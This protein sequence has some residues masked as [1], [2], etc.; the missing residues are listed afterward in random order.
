MT[1]MSTLLRTITP[2]WRGVLVALAIVELPR[3][4][5]VWS[6][7]SPRDLG[8]P[9]I[10]SFG[11]TF[12]Y[13]SALV[14]RL[15]PGEGAELPLWISAQ[16]SG[17]QRPYTLRALEDDVREVLATR[18]SGLVQPRPRLGVGAL[19]DAHVRLELTLRG[20]DLMATRV[21][22]VCPPGAPA[23]LGGAISG[24][25]RVVTAGTMPTN[26]RGRLRLAI[27]EG[28]TAAAGA[29]CTMSLPADPD[30]AARI[31]SSVAA[32]DVRIGHPVA[33]RQAFPVSFADAG[34]APLTGAP[35]Y[36]IADTTIA[37]LTAL[38]IEAVRPGTT[39]IEVRA[40]IW[41]AKGRPSGGRAVHRVPLVA[42][43]DP[44]VVS[45]P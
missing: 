43:G 2:F 7:L 11:G 37:R 23:S 15:A 36:H 45:R 44:S 17:T 27:E 24:F 40:A 21:A 22:T 32:V 16:Q 3:W 34:G 41:D 39:T 6:G 35:L 20:D 10:A 18:A 31:V 4:L 9:A 38:G 5:A 12:A 28:L 29:R 19:A 8:T 42:Q 25:E 14:V 1:S 33:V 30:R 13:D 26:D